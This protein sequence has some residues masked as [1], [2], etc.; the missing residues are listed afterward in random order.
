MAKNGEICSKLVGISRKEVRSASKGDGTR[1]VGGHDDYSERHQCGSNFSLQQPRHSAGHLY[2][3]YRGPGRHFGHD[4]ERL[5]VWMLIISRFNVC[6]S[7]AL[8]MYLFCSENND[9]VE[10][11]SN[12]KVE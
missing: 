12:C 6:W 8:L 1:N 5:A 7:F 11:T 9:K 4:E 2:H 10:C 3:D